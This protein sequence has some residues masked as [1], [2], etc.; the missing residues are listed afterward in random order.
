MVDTVATAPQPTANIPSTSGI[1]ST[2]PGYYTGPAQDFSGFIQ[3]YLA[4]M[5]GPGGFTSGYTGDMVASMDPYQTQAY[6]NGSTA[7]GF[8]NPYMTSG[9]NSMQTG[10]S[11]LDSAHNYSSTTPANTFDQAGNMINGAYGQ[12]GAADPYYQ[13]GSGALNQASNFISNS[14]TYN[15]NQ[16]MQHLSPY[17]SGVNDEIERRANNNLMEK[18]M[19]EV[20][21]TFAGNGQFGSTRNGTFLNNAI[22]NN[23]EVVSGAQA[24]AMNTAYGQ[25]ADDYRSWGQLGQQAGNA[26]TNVGQGYS[27]LGNDV[28]NKAVSGA[29]MGTSLGNLGGQQANYATGLGGLGSMLSGLGAD[30][31]NFGITG[32]NQNWNDISN[33]YGLGGKKQSYNQSVLDNGYQD[34]TKRWT[35]PVDLAGTLAKMIPSYTNQ[36]QPNQFKFDGS[37]PQQNN[38]VNDIQSLLSY[39]SSNGG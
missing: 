4:K 33:L 28:L 37:V 3:D 18:V 12:V 27:T 17:L 11:W 19:P 5:N 26:M 20:N 22:R 25:A 39:L 8:Q 2:L 31:G 38:S 35:A 6:N 21:S 32:A 24:S 16:M 1:V 7:T 30:Y 14:A 13:S 10:Q 34:W 23:Q 29:N 15:P 9:A 36:L